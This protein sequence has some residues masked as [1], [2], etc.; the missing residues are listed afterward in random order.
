VE[1]APIDTI[2]ADQLGL[3]NISGVLVNRVFVDSPAEKTG[4]KRGDVILK[5]NGRNTTDVTKFQKITSL[6]KPGEAI[7]L[8][9]KRNAKSIAMAAMLESGQNRKIPVKPTGALGAGPGEIEWAG[10]EV[11]PITPQ[12]AQKFGIRKGVKGV[13]VLEAEGMGAAAGI[14]NGDVIQG[15][16]RKKIASM[17]DFASATANVNIAEGVLFDIS[18]QGDPLYITM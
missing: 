15:L 7:T 4:L 9:T 6:L 5:I 10:M 17:A 3:N 2:M 11:V 8:I 14:M 18:R 16:N 12:L 13:M 1:V